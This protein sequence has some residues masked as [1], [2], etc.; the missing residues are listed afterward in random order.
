M[1][2]SLVRV[3]DLASGALQL[4]MSRDCVLTQ[5]SDRQKVEFVA[6]DLSNCAAGS[7][8]CYEAVYEEPG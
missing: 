5:S 4:L 6:V 2:V 8:I 3:Q 1:K 7:T